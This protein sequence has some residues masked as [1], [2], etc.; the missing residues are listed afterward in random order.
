MKTTKAVLL[1]MALM[2]AA[3][4]AAL[5]TPSTQIWIPSTDIQKYKTLHL[6]IDNYIRSAAEDSGVRAPNTYDL[7]LTAGVLPYEK[8]Q[9]EVG[10]DL[11]TNGTNYDSHPTY[12]NA[13][14]GTPEGALF[15]QSPALALGGFMFGTNSD[16]E[17]AT[18]TDLNIVY[19]LAAKTLPVVGR[20]S[21]GY[22][23]GN[24]AVLKDENG[25]HENTGVLLS[26]DRTLTEI[27]DKLWA[28]V[29]YQGGNSALG[30]LS[31]GVSYA[32]APN[33]SVIVGYD[34]Y[35]NDKIAGK[36]TYT[37]QLDINFP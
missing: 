8:L 30:A 9:M 31:F 33:V 28:S 7:G 27:S 19:A 34:M 22:F 20:L 12:G 2:V 35:N 6:G 11:I 21:A 5:A 4:V 25:E 18:R 10:L 1:A 37:T 29:D 13:K 16:K 32:F 15:A 23:V 17:S 14:I 24:S 3:T 26:W 36:D